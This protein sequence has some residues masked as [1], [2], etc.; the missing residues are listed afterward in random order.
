MRIAA[1]ASPCERMIDGKP[2]LLLN[3]SGCPT[4]HRGL[5]GAWHFKRLQISGEERYQDTPSKNDESH[6]CDGAGYGLL[7]AGEFL[8]LGGRNKET[9]TPAMA[10]G[11]FDVF[12]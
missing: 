10:D 1:L 3:K 7:G 9:R 5:S 12:R 6:I 11:S 2:G 8:H 4:L